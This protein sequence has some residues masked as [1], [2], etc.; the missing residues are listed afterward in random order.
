M[1]KNNNINDTKVFNVCERI[2][3]KCMGN[4]NIEEMIAMY[5]GKDLTY[6]ES[7]L[8]MDIIHIYYGLNKYPLLEETMRYVNVLKVYEC[9]RNQFYQVTAIERWGIEYGDNSNAEYFDTLFNHI[10]GG[11]VKKAFDM[12]NDGGNSGFPLVDYDEIISGNANNA[13][14]I[15]VYS[16]FVHIMTASAHSITIFKRVL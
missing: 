11:D 14:E 5:N 6:D 4:N 15:V 2:I 16:D 9:T 8:V 13:E 12:L 3:S 7:L 10:I 1:A